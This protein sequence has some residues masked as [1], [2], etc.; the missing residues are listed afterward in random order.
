MKMVRMRM[1]YFQ[2]MIFF[3][4]RFEIQTAKTASIFEFEVGVLKDIGHVWKSFEH[5]KPGC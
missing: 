3:L 1:I 5:S 2:D 4:R